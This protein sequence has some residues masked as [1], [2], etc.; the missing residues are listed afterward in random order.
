MRLHLPVL[1]ALAACGEVDDRATPDTQIDDQPPALTNVGRA[2]FSFRAIGVANSFTC[3]VDDGQPA[4]CV[5]PLAIDLADGAHTFEVAA[6]FDAKV[7]ETPATYTWTID[8]I[9]PETSLVSAPP[10]I[11]ND[12]TP[13]FAF[14]GEDA[15]GPVTLECALDGAAAAPCTSPFGLDVPDGEHTFTIT[16]LDAA[17]NRDAT[18]I[19]HGW[20]V[21]TIAPD[22]EITVFPDVVTGPDN[23]VFQFT[24]ADAMATFECSLDAATFTPCTSPVTLNDLT[25]GA[26][27]FQVRAVGTAG[28]DPSPATRAWTVDAIAPAVTLTS[29]PS[30][31]SNDTTPAFAF[32]ASEAATFECSLDGGAFAA[33]NSPFDAPVLADGSRVFRVRATDTVGNR[34][35]ALAFAWTIDTIAPTVTI[36]T[37]PA[38]LS[39]DTTPTVTFTT[40]GSPATTTCSIDG[41]SPVACTSPFT[42]GALADG[43]HA[44]AI[45]VTDA[46]GNSG[47]A[48]TGTFVI[49][50]IAP[51]AT[52]T[53]VPEALSNNNDP[54]VS[55]TVA[56]APTSTQC[57]LD[58]GTFATCTSPFA[59]TN[60]ADGTHTISVRVTDG[61]GNTSTVTT[62][63]FTI[64]TVA[65]LVTITTEPGAN[66]NNNDP[67]VAFTTAGN[68]TTTECRLDAGAFAP[69]TSP[70]A[71]ANVADGNHTITVRVTDGAGNTSSDTTASFTID[72]IAPT[73]TINTQPAA[74][75]NDTTPTVGFTTAG[76]PA[77]TRCRLDAGTPVNCAPPAVTLT[78]GNGAHTITITVTDTAGNA[79][80]ATT[81]SFTIDT[82]PPTV[83]FDDVPPA[84]W[85]VDYF[86]MQFSAGEPAT[87]E[88]SLNGAAFAA[89]TSP[90]TVTTT[91]NQ[92]STFR[93]RATDSLGNTSTPIQT[94][95]TSSDGLV[96]H[97]PWEQGRA[98]N[99]S[100]LAQVPAYSPDGP[101]AVSGVV[102]GWAGT[103][104]GSA[105]SGH[106]YVGTRR[107]LSSSAVAGFYTASF[108]IRS[109]DA[110]QGQNIFS[111]LGATGGM[112]VSLSNGSQLR[113]DVR[114]PNGVISSATTVI[115][116]DRWV[117]VALVSTGIAKGVQV[118]VDG[119]FRIVVDAPQGTGFDPG[120]SENLVVGPWNG[121]DLDDLRFFNRAHD[122]NGVCTTLA[123]GFRNANGGCVPLSPGFELDFEGGRVADTGLWNLPHEFPQG[124]QFVA[125]RLGDALR[126][127]VGFEWRYTSGF[128][129]NVAAVPAHS[130][131][132]WFEAGTS[133]GRL[134][135]FTGQCIVG[136]PPGNCGISIDYVDN[137]RI[138]IFTGTDGGV[139]TQTLVEVT[140]N[141]MNNVVVTE[142][143]TDPKTTDTITVFV[144]G[145]EVATIV[146]GAGDI[147]EDV[148]DTIRLVSAPGSRV[149]EFEFWALDLSKNPEAL[150]QNGFDGQFDH[151]GGACLLTSN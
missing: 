85:P 133:F 75:S 82:A 43:N 4:P 59:R 127:S 28:V 19:V 130:F 58:N 81:N 83:A 145:V 132:L 5:P 49:D 13:E 12:S 124:V 137:G 108:W 102:G 135:D 98:D 140:P 109:T 57:R 37:P 76:S 1:F 136:G 56:G 32:T 63:S 80:S 20:R 91:Y 30:N 65:P 50:T 68:P 120:Q 36:A 22:T 73:V 42:S 24:S 86:D 104:L 110:A 107:A 89:C 6:A 92:L 26:H 41:A 62:T 100:L 29:T 17:G 10:A 78:A 114:N 99:T 88:C 139:S 111:N 60:V 44:I 97:Y 27:S 106:A 147:Y 8:T 52:F 131:S 123:R 9:A 48:N 121:L 46:A 15:V 149:D 138:V 14:A 150:C 64:D 143:K 51:T 90:H 23:I 93:V 134:I 70:Q 67:S 95:W 2:Q 141:R 53:A 71:F 79:A 101:A 72:T 151:I 118:F 54:S 55:F 117:H 34:G 16:A 38:L 122:G 142:Q 105:V 96:L 33:C 126:L 119:N 128:R 115:A 47:S 94:A 11:D 129:A 84:G 40:A 144:N 18:P 77:T 35:N 66:T 74:L 113:V 61:A 31:P 3:R 21:T 39:N 125:G 116:E 103:A 25:N 45:T 7:D 148:S 87:F 112:Q 69:C 146:I